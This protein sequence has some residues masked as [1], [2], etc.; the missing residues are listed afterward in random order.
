YLNFASGPWSN[1]YTTFDANNHVLNTILIR[2]S[3]GAFGLS[4]LT[5]RLPSV[6]AGFALTMGVFAVLGPI[7]SRW[8]RWIA[9]VSIGLHPLILDFSVAARGYGISL[10]FLVWAM[11]LAM[12]ERY[13]WGGALLG[14]AVSANLSV[15][16]PALALICAASAIQWPNPSRLF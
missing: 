4:E 13:L 8:T 3:V 11:V 15:A 5:L 1:L 9:F 2:L 7:P 6:L 10:A 16:F 12:R 14:L